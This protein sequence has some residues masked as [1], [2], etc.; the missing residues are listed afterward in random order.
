[1]AEKK[2]SS[3]NN[4]TVAIALAVITSVTS[5]TTT[6]INKNENSIET[7]TVSIKDYNVLVARVEKLEKDLKEKTEKNQY[8]DKPRIEVLD[9]KV[10]GIVKTLTSDA[11]IIYNEHVTQKISEL[12]GFVNAI[13]RSTPLETFNKIMHI[14]ENE[15]KDASNL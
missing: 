8:D 14:G 1:M 4:A 11:K 5:L 2:E 13:V 9:I 7:N 12:F 3:G 6:L 10:K 15:K